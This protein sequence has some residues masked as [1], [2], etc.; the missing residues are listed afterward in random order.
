[1]G[2]ARYAQIAETL[3]AAGNSPELPVAI[4]ERGTLPEQR[5]ITTSLADLAEAA[6]ALDIQSPALLLVGATTGLAERYGW[7]APERHV[8]YKG[9]RARHNALRSRAS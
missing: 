6:T 3:L 8:T 9:T 1:M 2:V 5:V 7:F 4:I